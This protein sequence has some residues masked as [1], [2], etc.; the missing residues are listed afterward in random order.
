[1]KT[2]TFIKKK[3]VPTFDVGTPQVPTLF[4]HLP[5]FND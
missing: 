3:I 2:D 1:M 4:Y 5:Q